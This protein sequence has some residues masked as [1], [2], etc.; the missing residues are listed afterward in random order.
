MT[1]DPP[2]TPGFPPGPPPGADG[3]VCGLAP[4]VRRLER[5]AAFR[6]AR[7]RPFVLLTYAQ[8]VDGSIAGP[9]RERI[10]L[11]GPEAMGLTHR[12]R[13]LCETIL[14]GIGTVLADDPRLGVKPPATSGP[15]PI[16]L[17][18]HLRIP[19]RARLLQRDDARPLLAHGPH[20]PPGRRRALEAAGAE[21][22]CCPLDPHGR[23]DAAWLLERL[24]RAAVNS[25]MVEG[26]A[27]VI[28]HFLRHRLADALMITICPR[29]L[30]GLPALDG[31][32]AA[33]GLA[34]DFPSWGFERVGTDVVFFAAPPWAD[35]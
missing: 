32:R 23:V 11:S 1:P 3:G 30:G 35:P 14:V 12:L 10:R 22:V 6:A 17:D 7:G 31:A 8:S 4:L 5:A 29:L 18:T 19:R 2:P 9:R 15:R 20:A 24:G 33:G 16:V 34:I 26:G 13:A 27:R 25:V 21:P 28:T